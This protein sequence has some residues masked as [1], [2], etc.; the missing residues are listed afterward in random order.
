MANT[1]TLIASNTL[2]ASA[3]S[4]TFS[5]IP[6]TFTDLVLRL[7]TRGDIADTNI[8]IFTTF[9]GDTASKYSG[10]R[11]QGNGS[12]TT[13]SLSSSQT[14]LNEG[15]WS[16]GTNFTADVFASDEFYIPSYTAAQNKPMGGFFATENNATSAILGAYAGLWRNTAAITSMTLAPYSGNFVSGSSFFLYGISNS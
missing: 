3:A 6:A 9:N 15:P 4:V 2:S 5:A 13:G 7:S 10:L 11:M 14:K 12:S 8:N 1:Y 16:Q